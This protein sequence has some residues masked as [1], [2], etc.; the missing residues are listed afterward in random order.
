M[1]RKLIFKILEGEFK[2]AKDGLKFHRDSGNKYG[3][4]QY[5]DGRRRMVMT[6]R[7]KLKKL[8]N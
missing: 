4:A 5:F 2:E 3:L 1:K 6:I 7:R 8:L